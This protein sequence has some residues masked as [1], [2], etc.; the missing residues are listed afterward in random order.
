MGE[1]L[2]IEI[3]WHR[4]RYSDLVGLGWGQEFEF[5]TSTMQVILTLEWKKQADRLN[6]VTKLASPVLG[7]RDLGGSCLLH[8]EK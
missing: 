6:Q 8:R 2:E 7:G 5:L 4:P 3:P 1:K